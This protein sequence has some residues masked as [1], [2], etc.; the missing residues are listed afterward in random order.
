MPVRRR[1]LPSD[2]GTWYFIG[3]Q[4]RC[5]GPME[6]GM[7][8]KESLEY[9]RTQLSEQINGFDSSRGFYRKINLYVTLTTACLS[10]ITTVLIGAN[11]AISGTSFAVIVSITALICSSAITVVAAYDGFIRSK[12][13]WIQKTDTWMSLQNL[14][15]NII[16]LEKKQNTPLSQD[17]IDN[18]YRQFDAILMGE[19]ES[20]KKVR[21]TSD[22]ASRDIGSPAP[23]T[24]NKDPST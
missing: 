16:Y 12:E 14:E 4:T 20:W 13:L 6:I 8:E 7:P 9:L 19:H 5:V 15:A 21:S 10:A 24:Q 17:Q 23:S 11:Q 18:F 3:R 2:C 1:P 22:S